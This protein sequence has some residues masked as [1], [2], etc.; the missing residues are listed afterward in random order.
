MITK[1]G[2]QVG[3]IIRHA[4]PLKVKRQQWHILAHQRRIGIGMPPGG[5]R[6]LLTKEMEKVALVDMVETEIAHVALG[7]TEGA[8]HPELLQSGFLARFAQGAGGR[9][10][11]GLQRAGGHLEAGVLG[12]FLVEDQQLVATGDVGDDFGDV[13]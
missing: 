13:G 5:G 9:V 3:H 6:F 11:A 8:H 12:A 10:F 2:H 1:I 7:R 4:H